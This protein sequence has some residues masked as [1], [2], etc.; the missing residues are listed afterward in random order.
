M[1]KSLKNEHNNQLSIYA[2]NKGEEQ[3]QK[4]EQTQSLR[5]RQV[6][7]SEEGHCFVWLRS[8]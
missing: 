4:H 7:L 6:C 2:I 8:L 5:A 3:V 1:E